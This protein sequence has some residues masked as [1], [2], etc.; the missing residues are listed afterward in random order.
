MF[1]VDGDDSGESVFLQRT[2][3]HPRKGGLV[4]C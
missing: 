1:D 3:I 4:V 2:P